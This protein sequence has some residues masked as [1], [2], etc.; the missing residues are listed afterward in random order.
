MRS[1][2]LLRGFPRVRLRSNLPTALIIGRAPLADVFDM[3]EAPHAHA[4]FIEP[5]ETDTR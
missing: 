5:A 4:L 3:P 1:L 2:T